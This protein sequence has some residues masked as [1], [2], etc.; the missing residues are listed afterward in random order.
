MRE[1]ATQLVVFKFKEGNTD[2]QEIYP[3]TVVRDR[4]LMAHRCLWE[5]VQDTGIGQNAARRRGE[6]HCCFFEGARIVHNPLNK[7]YLRNDFY[8]VRN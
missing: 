1:S 3:P 8:I 2:H 7:F 6:Q 4:V 5:A